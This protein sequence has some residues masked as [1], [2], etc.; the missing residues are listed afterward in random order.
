MYVGKRA[1]SLFFFSLWYVSPKFTLCHN[2][3]MHMD[4]GK[5]TF[6]YFPD[7]Y[8]YTYVSKTRALDHLPDFEFASYRF[9][10]FSLLTCIF[11]FQRIF[12]L[13]LP[14]FSYALPFTMFGQANTK[15]LNNHYLPPNIYIYI[16]V[17]EF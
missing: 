8:T 15:P 14:L 12:I 3:W 11:A 4:V 2:A 9:F 7:T 13:S 6:S 10:F 5:K 1:N 16:R 17:V